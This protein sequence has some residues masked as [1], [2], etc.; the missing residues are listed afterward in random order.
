MQLRIRHLARNVLSNWLVTGA[1][2]VVGFFLAPFIVHHLGD[3]AYGV[4]ILAVSSVNYLGLLDL[5]MRSSVLRFVSKGFASQDHSSSSE[6]FSAALWVRAPISAGVLLLSGVLVAIFPHLFKIP[7]DLSIAAE[8]AVLL[9]GVNLASSML[10]GVF[11]GVLSAL[12]RYD[13]QSLVTTVQLTVRVIGVV[14]V[15]RAGYGIVAIAICELVASTASNTL[16]VILARRIYPEL[17]I[18]MRRP[19]PAILRD[20]WSY[21]LYA[22]LTTVAVQLVYQTD[23]LVVG[24]FVSASAVT[25]YAIGNSLCR[26]TDQFAS[27]MAMTFV[28]AASAYDATGDLSA[29][30]GLYKHGT[31]LM[32]SLV[33]PI[34]ITLLLRGHQFIGLWMGK[35]YAATSGTV[36][37]ILAFPLIFS[38]GNRI[39][40][41]I[42]FGLGKHQLPAFWAIG[43]GVANLLLSV[44]LVRRIG[45][46][47]VAIGTLIP[48]LVA[49]LGFW[50]IYTK[51]LTGINT[52]NIIG[53]LWTPMFLACVPFAI[54]TWVLRWFPA[55]SLA[56]F[57]LQTLGALPILLLPLAWIYRDTITNQVVP[58]LRARFA[59]D[60]SRGSAR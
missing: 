33:L 11:G 17:R 15:L 41:S 46:Y 35:S 39:A 18:R 30:R 22:F 42:A 31:R 7:H 51:R 24:T 58:R 26:Y 3:V 29:L 38:Y 57:A 34:L 21:S 14:I 49:Q 52:L 28:P 48:S 23:N 56:V 37:A 25:F 19:N 20:L 5:G 1:N 9:I 4:W 60:A 12:N 54:A 36:L 10:F 8:I 47:G 55:R 2:M 44:I 16:L 27:S 59:L 32:L 40:V 6:A 53:K 50:P 45:I 13:L 43:E